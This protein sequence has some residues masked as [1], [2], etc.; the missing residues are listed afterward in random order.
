VAEELVR[1]TLIEFPPRD[2]QKPK[3]PE[4]PDDLPYQPDW[5]SDMMVH[6]V[7]RKVSSPVGGTALRPSLNKSEKR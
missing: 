1:A 7:W 3:S 6:G 2:D 5:A 4:P